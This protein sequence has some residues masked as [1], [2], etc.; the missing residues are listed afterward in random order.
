MNPDPLPPVPSPPEHYWRQFRVKMVPGL[1]MVA[2]LGL[3]VWLWGKNL[4]NPVVMG[5]A[6]S[7]VVE[8]SSPQ[9]GRVSRLHVTLFQEV[10]VGD[11]IAV[12]DATDP[13]V[14]SNTIAVVRAEMQLIRTEAGLDNGDKIRLADFRLSWM[15]RRAELAATRAQ[16]NYAQAEY[17]RISKLAAEKIASAGG[18]EG[19][20]YAR[21][22]R[23]QLTLEIEQLTLAVEAAEKSWRALETQATTA[24]GP[25]TRA[26]LAVAE[27]NLKLAEAQ[28]QPIVL[29]APISGRISRLDKPAGSTV[30]EGLPIVTIASTT[31][32]CIIGYLS[33]PLRL[34]PKVGM[35]AEVRSRGLVR[36]VGEARVTDIGPRIELFDAPLRVRG[37]GAAQERGLPIVISMPPN[38][39]IRPGELVDIRLLLN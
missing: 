38:M 4:A 11:V 37:M 36:K 19:L 15:V 30:T 22:Y 13:L 29:T 8:I 20:D 9:P 25:V 33:Q 1:V 23:D 6:E 39:M 14:L 16:L 24:E 7:I 18:V 34:E 28:L 3:T 35:R 27:E 21:A 31:P 12:V 17:E 2:V 32:S 10:K 5:Q 26:A